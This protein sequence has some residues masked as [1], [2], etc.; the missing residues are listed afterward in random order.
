MAVKTS[1]V[2]IQTQ[3]EERARVQAIREAEV[4]KKF[5]RIEAV[6]GMTAAN[7][8]AFI[9]RGECVVLEHNVSSRLESIKGDIHDFRKEVDGRLDIIERR[10]DTLETE[11]S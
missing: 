5:D 1:L 6:L 2:K 8:S 7:G 11:A 9:R 4:D 3:L 10:V